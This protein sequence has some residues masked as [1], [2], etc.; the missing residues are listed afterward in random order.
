MG[1]VP[2]DNRPVALTLARD[3]SVAVWELLDATPAGRILLDGDPEEEKESSGVFGGPGPNL[4]VGTLFD[5][6]VALVATYHGE[7]HIWDIPT[8]TRWK[9]LHT[10]HSGGRHDRPAITYAELSGRP[11]AIVGGSDG[12]VD[13]WD[14]ATGAQVGSPMSPGGRVYHLAFAWVGDLPLLACVSRYP[15][16]V[17]IWNPA[18]GQALGSPLKGHTAIATAVAV[19]SDRGRPVVVSGGED[20]VVRIWDVARGGCTVLDVGATVKSLAV[21]EGSTIVVGTALGVACLKRL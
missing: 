13:V 11:V 5:R 14:L 12:S 6:P 16:V 4:A 8:A 19:G 2:L 18:T 17:T 20:R 7:V 3:A 10:A 1:A 21:G 15:S 9:T